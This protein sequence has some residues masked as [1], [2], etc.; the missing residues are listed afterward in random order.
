MQTQPLDDIPML[1]E[2]LGLQR[3]LSVSVDIPELIY[4]FVDRF[5]RMYGF[6]TVLGLERRGLED[7]AYRVRDFIDATKGLS[8]DTVMDD[9]T[10][11]QPDEA[12]AIDR[13]GMIAPMIQGGKPTLTRGVDTASD[14]VLS[15]YLQRQCDVIG[16]PVFHDGKLDEWFLVFREPGLPLEPVHVR[17]LVSMFN[18]FSRAIIQ[19]RLHDD[20]ASL[21]G[22]LDAK[23]REV[24]DVQQSI[25]P[26]QLPSD[27]K[28]DIAVEYRP[29]DLAGGDYY[30]FR[31][32][33]DGS[34]GIVIADV[35]GHGPG[36]AVVMAM[37]RTVM[38]INR[39]LDPSAIDIVQHVNRLLWDGLTPGTFV[40][41]FFV[42][43]HPETGKADYANAGHWPALLRKTDGRIERLSEGGAPPIGMLEDI[44]SPGGTTQLESGDTLLLYTDGI[45]ETFNP[46][47]K[48][49]GEDRLIQTLKEHRPQSARATLDAVCRAVDRYADGE[50]NSDDQCMVALRYLG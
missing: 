16:V 19:L 49:F 15:R 12:V 21:N 30:D 27:Q 1:D 8:R 18:M 24:A 40:T 37:L 38:S 45:T 46:G 31:S 11:D 9:S 10:W 26:Q 42:K 28:I 5:Y 35:S 39:L 6:G 50:P 48:I 33:E 29:S 2:V 47:G 14:P 22:Q 34:V 17:L 32:F 4:T 43:F 23:L 3:A 20:V 44:A 41:A 36:A 13:G 7:D 25:L